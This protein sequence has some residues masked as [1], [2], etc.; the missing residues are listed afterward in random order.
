[1]DNRIETDMYGFGYTTNE[2]WEKRWKDIVSTDHDYDGD[3]LIR[4]ITH[5]LSLMRDYFIN[6][7]GKE[8]DPGIIVNDTPTS[9]YRVIKYITM[10][11]ELGTKILTFNYGEE[12]D[13]IFEE[14]GEPSWLIESSEEADY[15]EWSRLSEEAIEKRKK[16]IEKFFRTI[17]RHINYWCVNG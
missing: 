7:A 9:V 3:F 1:M 14:K 6:I 11:Y 15:V 4:L 16:D 17:G 5:K 2:L 12:A 10:A 13:K 8:Q